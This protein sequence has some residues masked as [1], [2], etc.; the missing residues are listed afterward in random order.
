[1]ACSGT[2]AIKN[3]QGFFLRIFSFL[4]WRDFAQLLS[5][6][7]AFLAVKNKLFSGPK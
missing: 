5:R 1:M 4:A 7:V 2:A 6:F 3:E